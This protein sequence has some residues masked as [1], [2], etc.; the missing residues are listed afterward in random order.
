MAYGSNLHISPTNYHLLAALQVQISLNVLLCG[1]LGSKHQSNNECSTS[2]IHNN[3][4]LKRESKKRQENGSLAEK[5]SRKKEQE[6]YTEKQ[7][8]R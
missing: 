1:W 6:D 3:L 2:A 8:T 5:M 7:E 4:A